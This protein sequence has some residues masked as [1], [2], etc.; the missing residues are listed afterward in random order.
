MLQQ[1]VMARNASRFFI[2]C[3][4]GLRC[5]SLHGGRGRERNPF[6]PSAE[7]TF[8]LS[9]KEKARRPSSC[10]GD[11]LGD[12]RGR[13]MGD[14]A[15]GDRRLLCFEQLLVPFRRTPRG[16]GGSSFR[17]DDVVGQLGKN[18][19]NA[20]GDSACREFIAATQPEWSVLRARG[21]PMHRKRIRFDI[22][23]Y[24]YWLLELRKKC[25]HVPSRFLPVGF[26][27]A[28]RENRQPAA[29]PS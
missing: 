3:K 6:S 22:S 19:H 29:V 8:G 23:N 17:P 13:L 15:L 16:F 4:N 24:P 18:H 9:I 14:W 10:L 11:A 2:R 26:L 7:L 5:N 20:P 28:R 27:D 1:G 21:M 12:G 25:W